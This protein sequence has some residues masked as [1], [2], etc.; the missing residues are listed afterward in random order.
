MLKNAPENSLGNRIYKKKY[1]QECIIEHL[2]YIDLKDK[3]Y[4]ILRTNGFMIGTESF[5]IVFT[6][7][8]A[9]IDKKTTYFI[10]NNLGVGLNLAQIYRRSLDENDKRTLQLL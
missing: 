7:L 4:K 9:S 8:A 1:N 2:G 5:S 3:S 10:A 6:H